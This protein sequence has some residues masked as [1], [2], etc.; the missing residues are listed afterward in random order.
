MIVVQDWT[1]VWVQVFWFNSSWVFFVSWW[2]LE[3]LY[4]EHLT[5]TVWVASGGR[6]TVWDQI[7]FCFHK[8]SG[9][10]CYRPCHSQGAHSGC[11]TITI[12]TWYS[13]C[14]AFDGKRVGCKWV[15][16]YLTRP[17]VIS[18]ISV[19]GAMLSSMIP[20]H[21]GVLTVD[22]K[23]VPLPAIW[24]DYKWQWETYWNGCKPNGASPTF[25]PFG[26]Q[27]LTMLAGS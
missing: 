26:H 24:N 8:C 9:G 25:N 1:V 12:A 22:V 11:A 5:T 23:L 18:L 17:N 27:Y 13:V 2:S 3:I 10:Q 6:A 21:S 15:Q 4:V 16:S 14:R 19:R 20:Y 7:W